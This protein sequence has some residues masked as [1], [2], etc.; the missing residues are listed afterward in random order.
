MLPKRKWRSLENLAPKSIPI[1]TSHTHPGMESANRSVLEENQFLRKSADLHESKVTELYGIIAEL[2]KQLSTLQNGRIVEEDEDEEEEDVENGALEE[3]DISDDDDADDYFEDGILYDDELA[4]PISDTSVKVSNNHSA[5]I[6]GP[7]QHQINNE[8]K[9]AQILTQLE[10]IQSEHNKIKKNL[11]DK[12]EELYKAKATLV[13]VHEEKESLAKKVHHLQGLLNHQKNQTPT[14]PQGQPQPLQNKKSPTHT[15]QP[16]HPTCRF[17][18]RRKLPTTQQPYLQQQNNYHNLTSIAMN[19]SLN[20]SIVEK[21]VNL[22]EAAD[23]GE[24]TMSSRQELELV[25]EKEAVKVDKLQNEVDFLL[26]RLGEA[27][28]VNEN[29]VTV[30]GRVE[31][32]GMGWKVVAER[33]DSTI[34]LYDILVALLESELGLLLANVKA[35]GIG[36]KNCDEKENNYEADAESLLKRAEFNMGTAVG[37]AYRVLGWDHVEKPKVG[38]RTLEH[39]IRSMI[40]SLKT[41]RAQLTSTIPEYDFNM[42][43]N[44]ELLTPYDIK[45]LQRRSSSSGRPSNHN[46]MDLETAVLMQ[47]LLSCREERAD[48]K[49]RLVC[50]ERERDFL[51][52]F[53]LGGGSAGSSGGGTPSG[54]NE[55][56]EN[57]NNQAV[58]KMVTTPTS[59]SQLDNYSLLHDSNST[60]IKTL[61]DTKIKYRDRVKLLEDK[62]LLMIGDRALMGTNSNI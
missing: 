4:T 60:L 15:H 43:A 24:L 50:A 32:W 12:D 3:L 2:Q 45:Q 42:N 13:K 17:A 28:N 27:K 9:L 38:P 1:K 16:N 52:G 36:K 49:M 25:L 5:R 22:N 30:V 10:T 57:N 56:E 40:I 44:P 31:S 6:M 39:H 33:G 23:L 51:A 8:K 41:S 55:A 53:L 54:L 62:I 11:S 26:G 47:E 29:L 61:E 34:E 46:R 18:S 19:M 7:N 20:S 37:A 59:P 14:S 21:L 58:K 35:A 48:L